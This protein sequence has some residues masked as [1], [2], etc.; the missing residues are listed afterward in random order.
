MSDATDK[1]RTNL[2][3]FR[4]Q[5]V[6]RYALRLVAQ[7]WVVLSVTLALALVVAV[8]LP[9]LIFD[10]NLLAGWIVA[11]GCSVA[12]ALGFAFRKH[13]SFPDMR[14]SAM[15]AESRLNT[16]TTN[17]ITTALTCKGK[18]GGV[19]YERAD[20]ELT[21]AMSLPAP[22][23]LTLR[24]VLATP[25]LTLLLALLV[26]TFVGLESQTHANADESP[27]DSIVQP[28][29]NWAAID[30]GSQRTSADAEAL[31][32]AKGL[33]QEAQAL[34]ESAHNIRKANTKSEAQ[35][36]LDAAKT[37]MPE[38]TA[39]PVLPE[40][41]PDDTAGKEELAQKIE[42]VASEL[43]A[44]SLAISSKANLDGQKGTL[45]NGYEV[46]AQPDETP[47]HLLKMP[48]FEYLPAKIRAGAG[49]T[50]ARRELAARAVKALEEIK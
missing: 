25:V 26:V 4:R 36:A 1:F 35:A 48:R 50:T 43:D 11:G 14:E 27:T 24:Q 37:N 10:V 23:L 12:L 13:V 7:S 9:W 17:A 46:I 19:I 34:R 38:N 44:K 40:V 3:Y 2:R 8:G 49:L 28:S 20:A 39:T 5:L 41:A 42:D 6:V 47:K 18:F 21:E 15:A 30:T 33:K 22:A 31:A 29:N 16:E 45:D 32:K